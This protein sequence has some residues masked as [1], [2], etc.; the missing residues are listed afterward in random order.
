MA[1]S[2]ALP[3]PPPPLPLPAPP[4]NEPKMQLL[5]ETPD[6]CTTG[7]PLPPRVAHAYRPVI[8]VSGQLLSI[9][10]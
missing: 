5:D 6:D 10:A 2:G 4:R 1:L 9:F 7:T 3:E 8:G